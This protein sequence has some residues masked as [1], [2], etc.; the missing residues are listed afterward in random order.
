[1]RFFCDQHVDA[2]VAI[3]LKK[4]GHDAWTAAEAGLAAA[5]DDDLTVYAS[6]EHAALI[7]HDGEF[8]K[9]RKRNVIGWHIWV[10]CP[11]WDAADLLE[12]H[13]PQVLAVLGAFDDL[14]IEISP[15]TF[16]LSHDWK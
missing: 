13:L 10:R 9:R 3:R 2:A 12:Q 15:K 6:K 14:F 4:L 7:T 16:R 5:A 1:L 11:E 8:S